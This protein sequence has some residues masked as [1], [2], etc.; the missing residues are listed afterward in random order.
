MKLL[1]L[2]FK[3]HKH[4]IQIEIEDRSDTNCWKNMVCVSYKTY[5]AEN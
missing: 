5:I 1:S 3:T 2:I 4:V